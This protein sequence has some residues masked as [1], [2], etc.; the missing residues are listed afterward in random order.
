MHTPVN[1]EERLTFIDSTKSQSKDCRWQKEIEILTEENED[2]KKQ[3][4]QLTEEIEKQRNT[5]S[6]AEK[7]FEVNYQELQ[8]DYACLLKVKSDLEDSKNKQEVEYKRK[9]KAL[10][11]ELHH[12]QRINPSIVKMKSSVFDDDK[13][14]IAEPLEIGEVVE[15]DTTELMEKLDGPF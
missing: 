9:L 10:S 3:C 7:N 11:E 14:F 12:L 1:E 6:F 8:E 13:T 2:L 15:K 4:I 5:F